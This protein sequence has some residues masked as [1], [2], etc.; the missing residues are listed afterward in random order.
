MK[1]IQL[2]KIIV[3]TIISVCGRRLNHNIPGVHSHGG[4]NDI[5]KPHNDISWHEAFKGGR[6]FFCV[7]HLPLRPPLG[8]RRGNCFVKQSRRPT[9]FHPAQQK[10]QWYQ[11]QTENKPQ[12]VVIK[13]KLLK[14]SKEYIQYRLWLAMVVVRIN[15]I[16][17][18]LNK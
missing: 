9:H 1:A 13:Y 17:Y 7:S 11:Y 3:R 10:K 16:W 15:I 14:K 12:K 18:I 6:I 4:Y 5:S 8:S 2:K